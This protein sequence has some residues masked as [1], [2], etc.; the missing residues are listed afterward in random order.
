METTIKNATVVDFDLLTE[1]IAHEIIWLRDVFFPKNPDLEKLIEEVIKNEEAEPFLVERGTLIGVEEFCNRVFERLPGECRGSGKSV[2]GILSVNQ[3]SIKLYIDF[4]KKG[5]AKIV[6]ETSEDLKK[7]YETHPDKN[8]QDWQTSV[9]AGELSIKPNVIF[10]FAKTEATHRSPEEIKKELKR[11]A[12]LFQISIEQHETVGV[13]KVPADNA[14][15]KVL[16]LQK[17]LKATEAGFGR[18][19]SE[20]LVKDILPLLEKEATQDG[21]HKK[22]VAFFKKLDEFPR[23]IPDTN[24]VIIKQAQDLTL[25]IKEK[26]FDELWILFLDYT[27]EELESNAE[28]VRKKDPI[29][30]GKLHSS[31]DRLFFITDWED[32][33]CDLTIDKIAKL[34]ER[35]DAESLLQ[36]KIPKIQTKDVNHIIEYALKQ[37]EILKE[38]NSRNFMSFVRDS[39][40][41]KTKKPN[42]LSRVWNIFKK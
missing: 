11:F 3:E 6:I 38:T 35:K 10:E 30:F 27:N 13:G 37:N 12:N 18:S 33:V 7:Y 34:L 39:E 15:Q 8:P 25:S 42:L 17:Q 16:I 19:L 2:D 14:A 9:M 28:K 5:R 23:V 1:A 31:D 36:I 29:V 20:K 40:N 21:K 32:E 24:K 22:K 26:I 41:L 4:V